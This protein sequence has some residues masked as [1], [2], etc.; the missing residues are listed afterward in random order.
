VAHSQGPGGTPVFLTKASVP[1]P[2]PLVDAD[3]ARRL[4][5]N[6]G[7]KAA[8]PLGDVKHPPQNTARA[9]C[10][11]MLCTLLRCTQATASR[12]PCAPDAPGAVSGCASRKRHA[13]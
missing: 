3:E 10:V 4:V 8:K 12:R 11:H 5:E 13:P 6:G 1:Q 2:L 9:V 7:L